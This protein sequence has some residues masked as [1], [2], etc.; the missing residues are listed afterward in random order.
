[1]PR[2]VFM[3]R[4]SICRRRK[5]PQRADLSDIDR[6][7]QTVERAPK[8]TNDMPFSRGNTSERM[9]GA[10][11]KA[12]GQPR[13]TRSRSRSRG[14]AP[15]RDAARFAER[16]TEPMRP[17]RRSTQRGPS[18]G[19]I[20][21]AIRNV[22]K[23]APARHVRQPSGRRRSGFRAVD[24][25]RHARAS[26]SVRGCAGSSRR[27]AATGSSRWRRCS[28]HGHVVDHVLR[29]QGRPDHGAEG[30]AAL[31]A[32]TRS[33]TRRSTRWRRRTRRIRCRPSIRTTAR[34]SP[35]P[36]S[37]TK[38]PDHDPADAD[39]ADRPAVD[40]RRARRRSR[41]CGRSPVADGAAARWSPLS[42]RR[43]PARAR[44]ASRSRTGSTAKSSAAIRPPSIAASTSAPTRCRSP[45]ARA[46]RTI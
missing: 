30:A 37:T 20:A 35:S 32:S 23:Y 4:G 42:V 19:V 34:S 39:A 11:P 36:S 29:R 28:M 31:R 24:P 8:P 25:V 3:R 44:S 18:A 27:S 43:P 40:A 17:I 41:S 14:A 13:P 38:T 15:R 10:P 46:F 33:T 2:F 5:P 45:A 7:A 16:G 22:Q 9:E 21:D 1:M 12:A 26:S 6:K